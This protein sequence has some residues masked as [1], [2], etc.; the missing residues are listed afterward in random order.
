MAADTRKPSHLVIKTFFYA[1]VVVGIAGILYSFKLLFEP[2]IASILLTFLLEPIVNYFETKGR[3]RLAVIVGMYVSVTLLSIAGIVF[4]VPLL[5][6]EAEAFRTDLPRYQDM[7]RSAL[8]NVEAAIAA[9]F[10]AAAIPNLYENLATRLAAYG[11]IDFQS[12]ASY[13]SSVFAILSVAVIVP[14]VTFFF[15]LDGHLIQKS[16]LR[17]VPNR[18]FEMFVLLF[19][20][21]TSALQLFIRGQLIDA[22]AVGI[23][24]S[25]G[26]ALIGLPYFLVIGIIAGLGNL[27]PY[28]GPI[29]GFI[30]ALFVVLV[31]PEGLTAWAF[32]KIIIVF[33]VVQ[34]IEGTFIYPIAV[35]KSVDL[36]PLIVII[37]I[38]VGSQIGGI[39]GML[40]AI[41]LISVI[42][43]T[44]EVLYA[45]LKSYSII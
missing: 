8:E 29:I 40:I 28:L 35:G 14:I 9:R 19:H 18:Y 38:T 30:P 41:P 34:F 20:K 32:V 16:L 2:I 11:K 25:V 23:M 33:A 37:G 42:K 27:I 7:I 12:I 39:A 10:P 3:N 36:H 6:T 5:L 17:M 43:V 31:S 22:L 45:N 13:A 1:L 26:L 4:L 24:T 44:L 15:L 21:I